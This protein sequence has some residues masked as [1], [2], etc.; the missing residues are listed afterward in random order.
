V[1]SNCYHLSN[2][3]IIVKIYKAE[4]TQ[5]HYF[6]ALLSLLMCP[7]FPSPRVCLKELSASSTL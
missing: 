5:S 2:D 1:Q 7:I 6:P 3:A 4:E